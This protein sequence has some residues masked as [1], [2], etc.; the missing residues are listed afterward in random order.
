M[1]TR[2]RLAPLWRGFLC[3]LRQTEVDLLM[4]ADRCC[5]VQPV[6]SHRDLLGWTAWT[7]WTAWT[8][9]DQW[10]D[11]GGSLSQME[12]LSLLPQL[13]TLTSVS[14]GCMNRKMVKYSKINYMCEG[15]LGLNDLEKKNNYEYFDSYCSC[16]MIYS[17]RGINF[18]TINLI[19][20]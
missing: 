16:N 3:W 10:G 14:V 18:Y 6:D 8:E 4:P 13:E 5:Q 11:S 1:L 7:A 20:I 19:F 12:S 17:V 2:G 15:K 9:A